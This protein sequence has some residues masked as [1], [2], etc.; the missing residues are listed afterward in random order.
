MYLHNCGLIHFSDWNTEG[1]YKSLVF[2]NLLHYWSTSFKRERGE[3]ITVAI[4]W[5]S[6]SLQNTID[7][8]IDTAKRP[9]IFK[10][11]KMKAVIDVEEGMCQ[12]KFGNAQE[13]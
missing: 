4:D 7:H 10:V 11:L 9:N 13:I 1:N 8:Y 3:R 2:Q 5:L 6:Q 12:S